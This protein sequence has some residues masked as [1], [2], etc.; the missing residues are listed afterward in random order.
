MQA[1]VYEIKP[2]P[3]VL[4]YQKTIER[5]IDCESGGQNLTILDSNHRYSHGLLQ[6]QTDTWN[7]MSRESGITGSP[8]IA[9]DARRMADWA[10]DHN[11]GPA[12]TCWGLLGL[13]R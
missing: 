6:F 3:L 4:K 5:L 11:R 12:W 9:D 2:E 1:A 10:I 7:Q 13:V 8:L